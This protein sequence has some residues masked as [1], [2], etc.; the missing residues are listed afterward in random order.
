V[1]ELLDGATDPASGLVDEG[2]PRR[3]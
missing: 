1:A 3:G 2:T